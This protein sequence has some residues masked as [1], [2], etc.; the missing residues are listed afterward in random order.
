MRPA[1]RCFRGAGSSVGRGRSEAVGSV[2]G[3]R[4]AAARGIG[5]V[6][7]PRGHKMPASDMAA[8]PLL[9]R[10]AEELKM[11]A[12]RKCGAERNARQRGKRRPSGNAARRLRPGPDS[13]PGSRRLLLLLLLALY[14]FATLIGSSSAGFP[15]LDWFP[16]V[17][18]RN[19]FPGPLSLP[20]LPRYRSCLTRKR[21]RS[22]TV[23]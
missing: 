3:R 19:P 8:A 22:N 15:H 13:S 16:G 11:A 6:A 7:E 10:P 4:P 18:W 1:G 21:L 12:S 2:R 5:H 9:P 14:N 17:P 23:V 20:W